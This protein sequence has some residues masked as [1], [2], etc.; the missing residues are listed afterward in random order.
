M[1]NKFYAFLLILLSIGF[2]RA[3]A[4]DTTICNARFLAEPGGGTQFFFRAVDSVTGLEHRWDFGDSTRIGFG[5]YVGVNHV[6]SHTGA[7]F[8]THVVRNTATGCYDSS[9]QIVSVSLPPPPPPSCGVSIR[10]R[11]DSANPQLFTFTADTHL[12]SGIADTYL[13]SGIV[14]TLL[15][16]IDGSYAGMGDSLVTVLTGNVH[17]VCVSLFTSTGCRADSCLVIDVSDTITTPHSHPNIPANPDSSFIRTYP[18]PSASV[19]LVDLNL[20]QPVTVHIRVYNSMGNQVLNT[21]VPGIQGI[22]HLQVPLGSLQSGI[23]YMQVQY[24]NE[25]K[26]SKIQKL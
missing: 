24:G 26:R 15:W 3:K 10:L 12:A 1:N 22:N 18:N 23:Y 20:T 13:A 19:A 2:G 16:R 9:T 25:I 4:A 8:V 7:F 6:Y 5:N 21:S 17:R 11:R 14:D